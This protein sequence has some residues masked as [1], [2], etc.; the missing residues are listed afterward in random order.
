MKKLKILAVAFLA[1]VAFSAAAMNAL[2]A[3]PLANR[4]PRRRGA[5]EGTDWTPSTS[6]EKLECLVS[7]GMTSA[8]IAVGAGCSVRAIEDRRRRL[9]T[10]ASSGEGRYAKA[11]DGIDAVYS[12]V[13]MLT[14]RF[15]V[16]P[17]KIR[18]WLIGRSAY[19][20][21]QRPAVLLGAGEFELVRAAALA[22]ATGETP[23]EFLEGRDPI[24]RAPDPAGLS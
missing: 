2:V 11:D 17:A 18:A 16:E 21:E 7:L 6:A 12:L 24:V 1:V 8:E 19:L 20:E 15:N 9:K 3:E 5:H 4:K 10:E 13:S 14:E 22:Y 23:K